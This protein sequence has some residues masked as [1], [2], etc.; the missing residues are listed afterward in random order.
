MTATVRRL[1]EEHRVDVVHQP[2][3]VSPSIPSPLRRLGAPVVMGPL[4][5]GMDLPAAFRGRDSVLGRLRK[6]ARRPLGVLLNRVLPGRLEADAVLV[7]NDRTRQLLPASVQSRVR[8]VSDVGVDLD[9]FPDDARPPD[10]DP[11]RALYVGRLVDWKSVDLLIEAFSRTLNGAARLR[12]VIVGDGP[13][14]SKLE[15]QAECLRLPVDFLGWLPRAE[16]LEQMRSSDF[17]VLPSL[18]EAGGAV[19]LEALA[20]RRP[21]IAADW[22]GPAYLLDET[23]G[24]KVRPT[25]REDYIAGLAS[26]MSRLAADPELRRRLGDAGRERVVRDFGWAQIAEAV[27]RVYREVVAQPA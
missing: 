3:S 15:R 9:R 20:C 7:A 8:R 22:G 1:V 27:E 13:E 6:H 18:A 16:V 10:G 25:S 26:A 14:R 24:I 12:F 23:C 5:G 17:L 11:P 19:I 21:V 4:N 2:I